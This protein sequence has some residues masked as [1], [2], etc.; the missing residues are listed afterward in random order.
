V[1]KYYAKHHEAHWILAMID[2][3]WTRHL[4]TMEELRHGIG[5]QALAQRDPLVEYKRQSFGLFDD[6]KQQMRTS[7]VNNVMALH[8]KELDARERRAL[9]KATREVLT[10]QVTAMRT[11]QP[12]AAARGDNKAAGA[13]NGAASGATN[14][15]AAGTATAP[16]GD[17]H[18]ATPAG[19]SSGARPAGGGQPPRGQRPAQ[20]T[21]PRGQ[22]G[23][24]PRGKR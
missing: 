14:G 12:T 2:S 15:A 13:G 21:P 8:L 11:N 16:N 6:L 9:K 3:L 19:A 23:K 5:L 4:T 10:K 18:R 20:H 22:R 7:I 17:G 1:G 24:P